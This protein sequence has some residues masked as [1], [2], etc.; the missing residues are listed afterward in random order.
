MPGSYE[1]VLAR[2]EP[3]ALKTPR[4]SAAVVLLR[5]DGSGEIEVFWARRARSMRFMGGWHAFPGGGLSPEDAAS[6]LQGVPRGFDQAS[7]PSL[8]PGWRGDKASAGLSALAACALREL[9]EETGLDVADASRLVYAGRWITPPF[10]SQ[11]YDTHFF[12]LALR[13]AERGPVELSSELEDGEWI[14]PAAAVERWRE[15][16]A[17]L[18]QPTLHVL[19]V[20]AENGPDE[21]RRRLQRPGETDPASLAAI[22]F[23]PGVSVVSQR[24]PT[25]PPATHTNAFLV[26]G[27]ERVLIDPGSAEPD[28]LARLE[29]A[30]ESLVTGRGGRIVE[31]WLTHHHRDHIGGAAEMRLRLGVP[32][33][34]HRATAERLAECGIEVD[35]HLEEGETVELEGGAEGDPLV[36]LRV[37]HTPGHAR[38]HL[39][40]FDEA[41]GA[42]IAGDMLA[43]ESTIV[44]DPPDGHMSAYLAS[45]DKLQSLRPKFLFPSHG[46]MFADGERRL[47]ALRKHRLWREERVLEAWQSGLREPAE[48][49]AALYD[50]LDK[51]AHSLA[52]RQIVA[53]LDRLRELGKITQ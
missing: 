52:E 14:R 33:R 51:A 31:I 17:L 38:G 42:L 24:T 35:G 23:R 39:C 1:D 25:L 16:K 36:R 29:L 41:D 47:G 20:L 6:P 40:F 46:A 32:L 45:L 5:R 34:A 49:L 44:I 10:S 8:T 43:S 30:I 12:S 9:S 37:L 50:G 3:A 11:R 15:G 48:F 27:R 21:G 2:V 18:A 26:G 22:E 53:H 13:P 28:E 7:S 4:D 19:R